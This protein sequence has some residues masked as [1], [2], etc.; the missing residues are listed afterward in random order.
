MKLHSGKD[1]IEI[2]AKV[3]VHAGNA[4]N[5]IIDGLN[6]A[7]EGDSKKAE[8]L[9]RKAEDEL[10][11]AH[12]IQTEIIQAEAKGEIVEISLLWNHAQDSL[13]AAMTELN[14]A[15]QIMRIYRKLNDKL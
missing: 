9:L 8:Q 2:A 10:R 11:A 6:A 4:R 15:R 1:L 5:T 7:S 3:I 13:M 12:H 14:M